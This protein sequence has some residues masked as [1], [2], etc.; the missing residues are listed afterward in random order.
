MKKDG[1][2]VG[3]QDEYV[4]EN[5]GYV[6]NKINDSLKGQFTNYVTDKDNQEKIKRSAKKG[7]KYAKRFGG[8][9]YYSYFCTL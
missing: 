2:Y 5:D 3:I 9:G 7:L 1:Q 6:D 4:P 8:T